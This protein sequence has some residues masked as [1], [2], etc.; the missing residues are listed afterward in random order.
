M[1]F[2]LTLSAVVICF[3]LCGAEKSYTGWRLAPDA[4]KKLKEFSRA[5]ADCRLKNNKTEFVVRAQL[6]YTLSSS[7]YLHNWYDRPLYQNTGLARFN[8]SGVLVNPAEAKA[9]KSALELGKISAVASLLENSGCTSFFK[10]SLDN[11]IRLHGELMTV[12]HKKSEN[13]SNLKTFMILGMM[14]NAPNIFRLNSKPVITVYPSNYNTGYL[15]EMRKI[16]NTKYGAD[17]FNLVPYVSFYNKRKFSPRKAPLTAEDIENM[18]EDLRSHLRHSDGIHIHSEHFLT[19]NR[20]DNAFGFKVMIPILHKIFSENEF[21]N[22][23]LSYGLIQGLENQYRWNRTRDSEGV[24]TLRKELEFIYALRPDVCL[25]AEWDEEN[26]NTCYRPMVN[27]GWSSL[28]MIRHFAEKIRGEKFTAFPGDDLSI[29]NMIFC[30]RRRLLAGET[31]EFQVTNIPDQTPE[32]NCKI[33]LTLCDA[34]GKVIRKFAPKNLKTTEC[35]DVTFTVPAVELLKYQLVKPRLEITWEGGKYVSPDSFWAQEIRADWNQDWQWAK[36][37][38]REQLT[39]VKA[40]YTITP[41]ENGLL[42]LKGRISSPVPMAQAEILDGSDTVWMADNRPALRETDT[43]AVI[44]IELH[45]LGRHKLDLTLDIKNAPNAKMANGKPVPFRITDKRWNHIFAKSF[46]LRLPKNEINKAILNVKIPGVYDE[47]I[48]IKEVMDKHV[49]GFNTT[50]R[51][52]TMVVSRYNSQFRIPPHIDKKEVDF[53]CFVIPGDVK[54]SVFSLRVID[55]RGNTWRGKEKSLYTPSGKEKSFTVYDHAA[56]GAVKISADE[57]LL[58]PMKFDFA[59]GRGTVVPNPAGRKYYALMNGCTP[60]VSNIGIGGSRYGSLLVDNMAKGKN[61]PELPVRTKEDDGSWSLSFDKCSHLSLPMQVV[62]MHTGYKI[63]MQLQVPG[64]FK[65]MQHIFGSGSH[66]FMLAVID[67]TLRAK[68]FINDLFWKTN[69]GTVFAKSKGKLIP[70]KWNDVEIIYDHKNF[71]VKLNGEP[72]IPRKVT[73]EQMYP[74]A[75]ILGGGEERNVSFTGKV[76]NLSIE[77]Y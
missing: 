1:K 15:K 30:Y 41:Y 45:G 21:K 35:K 12:K 47:N 16:F 7:N 37:P 39:G 59:P 60:L 46:L 42:R 5:G 73:G 22:K 8:K 40:D 27:T 25:L 3:A 24:A 14:L 52:L 62:P 75:G 17:K 31:A 34:N 44:K 26:E 63:R 43:E 9:L 38:L 76:R 65:Q 57:N 6:K 29:P 69:G 70:G 56:K 19:Y 13:I 64:H 71:Y 20:V 48:S 50:I 23:F 68:M 58:T 72:G 2:N 36:H 18:A 67:G 55:K 54:K 11:G 74:K 61:F 28:R 4:E 33:S 53:D 77:V 66:G 10:T 51:N 49:L 32:R